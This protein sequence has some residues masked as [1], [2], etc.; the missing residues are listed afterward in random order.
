[1]ATKIQ[2]NK[3]IQRPKK[4][5]SEKLRRQ[6]NQSKR[7]VALGLS[8][9]EVKKLDPKKVRTLLRKPLKVKKAAEKAKK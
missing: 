3:N 5:T 7:L 4:K 8:E 9:E 1:M 2:R 6:R